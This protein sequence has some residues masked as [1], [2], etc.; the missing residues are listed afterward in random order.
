M[1]EV[2]QYVHGKSMARYTVG[3]CG[4]RISWAFKSWL[5][6][7]GSTT[8]SEYVAGVEIAKSTCSSYSII[9]NIFLYLHLILYTSLIGTIH[10]SFKMASIPITTV[11]GLDPYL[12]RK[13]ITACHIL[14]LHD[15]V[16]AYG[17]ISVR[18]S[19][20]T[21]LMS[22]YLAPALVASPADLV[23]YSV[24]NAEPLISNPPRG[25]SLLSIHLPVSYL[26]PSYPYLSNNNNK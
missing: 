5:I 2:E 21:F 6:Y 17:H 11:S 9:T 15:L 1:Y 8:V 14:H 20:T 23:I 4:R 16:D 25:M 19:P 22:R 7:L 13:Y 18:L 10:T 3:F 26:P 12:V 24:D